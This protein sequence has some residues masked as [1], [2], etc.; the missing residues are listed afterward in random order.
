MRREAAQGAIMAD[1]VVHHEPAGTTQNIY[2]KS[3]S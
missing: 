3:G 2:P 1:D